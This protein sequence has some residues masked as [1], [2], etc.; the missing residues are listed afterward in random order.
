MSYDIRKP[1]ISAPTAEGQLLQIKSYLIQLVDQLNFALR[2]PESSAGNVPTTEAEPSLKLTAGLFSEIKSLIMKSSDIINAYYEK[3]EPKFGEK[4]KEHNTAEDS[5]ADIRALIEELTETLNKLEGGGNGITPHI[6][7]NGNWYIGDEDTG[8][9]ASGYIPVKG[10]D[11]Y[12][13][14]DKNEMVSRVLAALPTW[15]GGS[16]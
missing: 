2:T 14:A 13:E 15:N 1:M 11:Y 10:I 3:M 12:T 8:V 9:S 5:H 6:G 16:Y 7:E 4:I